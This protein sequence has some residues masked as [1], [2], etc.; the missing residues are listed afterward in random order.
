MSRLFGNQKKESSSEVMTPSK[1]QISQ[2]PVQQEPQKDDFMSRLFGNEKKEPSPEVM[3]PSKS[4]ISQKPVQQEPQKDDFMSRLFGN[5]KKEPSPEVMTPS[6]SQISQKPL[7][8]ELTID[9]KSKIYG[10][11]EYPHQINKI[12][13]KKQEASYK[14]FFKD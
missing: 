5:E 12:P 4:Q 10:T 3:T 7:Q 1:P 8:Q 11:D 2:K 6:K 13:N 14:S 9:Y